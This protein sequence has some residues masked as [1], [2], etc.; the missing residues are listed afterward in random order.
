[1]GEKSKIITLTVVRHG[2]TDANKERLMQGHVDNPLNYFGEQQAKAAG[3]SLKNVKFHQAYTSDLSRAFKT[4]Q[5]ILEENSISKITSNDIIQDERIKEQGFGKFENGT[6]G[7]FLEA[8]AEAN[9][10]PYEFCPGSMESSEDVKNRTRKFMNSIIAKILSLDQYQT[11]IL[12]VTHGK[13]IQLLFQ[14]FFEEMGCVSK[15]S[16]LENPAD[17]LDR[18]NYWSASVNTSWSRFV[19]EVCNENPNLIKN[20]ECHDLFNKDHLT[21]LL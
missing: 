21:N 1:M 6:L 11:S 18:K 3:K 15:I 5:L 7:A 8:A 14:M 17:L 16:D 19:I 4:C 10:N 20:I 13:V 9:V 2:Q 12:M